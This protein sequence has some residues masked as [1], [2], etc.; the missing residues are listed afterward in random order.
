[1]SNL[2]DSANYPTRE[3]DQLVV[4][5]RWV[6]KRTDLGADYPP[7]S[8]TLKYSLRLENGGTTEI[9]IIAAA[10][11]SDYLIEVSQTTTTGKTAGR[12]R[13]QAYIVRNSDSERV[14]VGSG[15][16]ELLANR[17]AATTD[18]RSHARK[19]LD[20]IE[21]AIEA[22]AAN[23]VKSYTIT[24]GTGSRTVTKHDVPELL[25]LRDRYRA[26]A[27]DEEAALSGAAA[28]GVNPRHIGI[29]FYRR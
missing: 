1:M 4:G 13:W 9:E 25:T 28:L 29:R 22:F 26:E 11:G 5:D 8:Y 7:A 27:R 23:T 21:A 10:S 17:D 20:S 24:T 15:I 19:V 18:P 3:P 16:V 14:T 2:F 12:Y 6:W